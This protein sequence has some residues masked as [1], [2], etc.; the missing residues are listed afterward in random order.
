V[1]L[2]AP[3]SFG[4]IPRVIREVFGSDATALVV[5]D[6]NTWAAAGSAVQKA[7]EA[8]SIRTCRPFLF[9]GSPMLHPDMKSVALLRAH[10]ERG[11]FLPVSVGAGTVNDIVKR[12]SHEAGIP[13]L[14]VPTAASVDGYTSFGAA[15]LSDGFKTTLE[16]P[17]P[18]AV[19][20]DTDVLRAAPRAMTAS[21]YAD[22][23]GKVTAGVDWRIAE[24]LGIEAV[25]AAAWEMVQKPL[26]GQLAAPRAIAAG[27]G[28]ALKA[29]MD[30]L[31][32]SGLAMQAYRSSRPASGA[33]H[34]LSHVW[35]MQ[36]L[37]VDGVPVSHG[38]KVGVG[39]LAVTAF[40]EQLFAGKGGLPADAKPGSWKA[41]EEREEAVRAAYGGTSLEGP[42]LAACR[43]KQLTRPRHEER[44]ER[45][46]QAWPR[47][48]E[49]V[50]TLLV[51]FDDMKRMLADAGCPVHPRSLG[52]SPQGLADTLRRA[53]MI[54]PRYTVLDMAYEMGVLDGLIEAVVSSPRYF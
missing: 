40:M 29:L 46:R 43:A 2:C 52:V 38:F 24:A 13:Y 26:R 41:W 53:Q 17:A 54:R 31:V 6:D 12:A 25:H 42:V 23:A 51:P 28:E 20:C 16:C 5:A 18:A 30:G 10:L 8:G 45:I 34:L 36:G 9:P 50:E 14:T 3:A 4:E 49:A 44:L 33:E 35:E 39:T 21:G 27:D 7:L 1:I 22:L 32:G 15:V 37:S 47:M 19:V 48:R 11:R